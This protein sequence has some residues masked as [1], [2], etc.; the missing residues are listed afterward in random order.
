MSS[1]F[2]S[3]GFENLLKR[4]MIYQ[5]RFPSIVYLI[6]VCPSIFNGSTTK[7]SVLLI[8]KIKVA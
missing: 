8:E 4:E 3:F 2:T 1:Q 6:L 7:E 5:F